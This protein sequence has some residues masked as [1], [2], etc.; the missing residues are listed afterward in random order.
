VLRHVKA[1][2]RKRWVSK[3]VSEVR[4]VADDTRSHSRLVGWFNYAWNLKLSST[5]SCYFDAQEKEPRLPGLLKMLLWA[6]SQL[7]DKVVYPHIDLT[8]GRLSDVLPQE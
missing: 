8:T 3:F 6:Q 7:D 5:H 2:V 4:G 1:E